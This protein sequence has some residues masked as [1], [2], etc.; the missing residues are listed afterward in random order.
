[1]GLINPIIKHQKP[2]FIPVDQ[3]VPQQE[4]LVFKHV[5]GAIIAPVSVFYGMQGGSEF[6]FFFVSPKRSY[7][8]ETKLNKKGEISPGFREHNTL[9]LNYFEKFYDQDK[10][11]LSAYG[12]MILE[13]RDED[14]NFNKLKANIKTHFLEDEELVRKI[15]SMNID[16]CK[17]SLP[18]FSPI[19]S[20][21]S[22]DEAV[23]LLKIS[24]VQT[25]IIPLVMN[26][27][28]LHRSSNQIMQQQLVEIFNM[29]IQECGYNIIAKLYKEILYII[30]KS[31]YDM[32]FECASE[33][34][35]LTIL[36]L[37]PKFEYAKPI[38]TFFTVAIKAQIKYSFNSINYKEDK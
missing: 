27:I 38:S 3:W 34:I 11:L 24:L 19:S 4:D 22:L 21:F 25:M 32:T 7:N 18:K 36:N 12:L 16:N 30:F 2:E 33:Y 29:V 9:Y 10:R 17:N 8:S 31:K 5:R 6:D 1:M 35:R 37:I 26:F 23:V 13:S 14:Y 28:S 20:K 15:N